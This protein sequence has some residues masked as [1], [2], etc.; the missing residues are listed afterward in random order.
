[1]TIFI[2]PFLKFTRIYRL[3]L[4]HA[5]FLSG[6]LILSNEEINI[7]LASFLPII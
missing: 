2:L 4:C 3:F 5:S 1:M 6:D 7:A